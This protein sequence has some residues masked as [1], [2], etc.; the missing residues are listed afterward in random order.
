MLEAGAGWGARW[1]RGEP[2]GGQPAPDRVPAPIPHRIPHL[3]FRREIE[4]LTEVVMEVRDKVP[5]S[6]YT[7]KKTIKGESL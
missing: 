5:I 1:V 7:F 3:V 6:W 4:P 2:F